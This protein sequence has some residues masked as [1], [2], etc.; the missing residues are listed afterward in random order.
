M[1][2]DPA[3]LNYIRLYKKSRCD[4][5][6]DVTPGNDDNY[7]DEVLSPSSHV[8]G[9]YKMTNINREGQ[10]CLI[11]WGHGFNTGQAIV[12]KSDTITT[13]DCGQSWG[14]VVTWGRNV[15]KDCSTNSI[16]LQFQSSVDNVDWIG[17]YEEKYFDK[18]H[19]FWKW[20]NDYADYDDFNTGTITFTPIV[21]KGRYFMVA[22]G[23]DDDAPVAKSKKFDFPCSPP[24]KLKY[25]KVP[26]A[27]I[28]PT[29]VKIKWREKASSVPASKFHL[30]YRKQRSNGTW[31]SWKFKSKKLKQ[32]PF[33]FKGLDTGVKYQVRMRG[34]NKGGKGP[35][36]SSSNFIPH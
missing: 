7:L 17:L 26:S 2:A 5:I 24:L 8:D 35:W 10:Y 28:R 33:R 36:L 11:A 31:T 3:K 6:Q 30:Q 1:A 13:P 18:M 14:E 32:S 34:K 27:G 21:N 20:K 15:Q 16:L 22:W 23:V 4:S 25:V 12:A 9:S 29:S 19:K